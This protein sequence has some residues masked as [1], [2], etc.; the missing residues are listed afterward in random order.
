MEKEELKESFWNVK[1]IGL[2]VIPLVISLSLLF[3]STLFYFG[4]DLYDD[5]L[6][7]SFLIGSLPYTTYRYFEFRRIKRYE[8]IFPDFLADVSS[9]VNSGMSIPQAI[10]ICARRDYGILTEEIKKIDRLI[11]WGI[12]FEE[13]LRRFAYYVKSPFI[14]K[15][16]YLIIEAN[17]SGGDIREILDSAS[18]NSKRLKEIERELKGNLAPYTVIMYMIFG[19][20]LAMS[21]MIY[22]AF[23]LPMSEVEGGGIIYGISLEGY[24]TLFFRLLM[25]VGLFNGLIMG[26][27]MNGKVIS[28][29]KH[30]IVMIV[31][32]YIVFY[33][34][35][36]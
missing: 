4:K 6:L 12:P 32:S 23:L 29:L 31:V 25:L 21:V 33:F 13:V 19:L 35:G 7:F 11:T 27:I 30:S 28:G 5:L 22:Y 34:L 2:I 18:R 8:E 1:N 14:E 26:K 9:S 3:Y 24:R 16:V 36:V 17:R 20:F 10:S 15:F